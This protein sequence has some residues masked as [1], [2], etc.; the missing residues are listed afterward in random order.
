MGR[1]GGSLAC[2]TL[3]M[4]IM[5][6][7]VLSAPSENLDADV[8]NHATYGKPAKVKKGEVDPLYVKVQVLLDR[9]RFS[10][11]VVDG[12]D[13]ENVRH[14]LKA[15]GEARGAGDD[16]RLDDALW[17]KL[18]STS[19]DPVV[20]EYTITPDD[21]KGPFAEDI[22]DKLE[23]QARLERLSYTSPGEMLSE[24]FHMDQEL[25]EALNPGKSLDRPGTVI[26][27][28]N[29]LADR[30]DHAGKAAR[31]EVDKSRHLVRALA[32]DGSLIAVYPASV[33]SDEKPAPSGTH[34]VRAI[35]R[36]PTYTY[37][38]EF[39]FKSVAT[40]EKFVVKPGP[41]NPVGST[42]ID[43]SAETYGIHGTP[44]PDKVGKVH[45]Q[46]CVRLTNWDVDALAGMVRKGTS[47]TFLE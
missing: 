1:L 2:T 31:I 47:V 20:T 46:G 3:C 40:K 36:N 4:A 28:A 14:A 45:S 32:E 38:P 13:G 37:N 35:A 6:G 23:D 9:A 44:H 17:T 12:H 33:G 26:L 16:G 5:I 19:S 27:V 29:V 43:L 22:P 30:D 34:T 15:F 10:P 21:L 18:A 8:I 39:R 11:G 7:P 41:N 24:R 25:L 42:W